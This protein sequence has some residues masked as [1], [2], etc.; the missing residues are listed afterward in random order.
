MT[1]ISIPA[2][3]SNHIPHFDTEGS[4]RRR[5][6]DQWRLVAKPAYTDPDL[7]IWCL[8]GWTV[9]EADGSQ[10]PARWTVTSPIVACEQ[11]LVTTASGSKYQLLEQATNIKLILESNQIPDE[12]LNKWI[13]DKNWTTI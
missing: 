10:P 2:I 3:V 11:G 1:S 4:L 13:K 8:A 12:Y 9:R 5:E 6:L 7:K